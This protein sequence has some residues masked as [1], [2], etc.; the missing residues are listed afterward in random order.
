MKWFR[1]DLTDYRVVEEVS[2]NVCGETIKTWFYIEYAVYTFGIK[3]YKPF[4]RADYT[5]DGVHRYTYYSESKEFIIGE[6]KK[7]KASETKII[8]NDKIC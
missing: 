7:M 2:K 8:H 1:K 5:L 3:R 6:F 4:E